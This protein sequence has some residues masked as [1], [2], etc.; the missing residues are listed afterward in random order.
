MRVCIF[1]EGRNAFHCLVLRVHF[2]RGHRRITK[3]VQTPHNGLVPKDAQ[4]VEPRRDGNVRQQRRVLSHETIVK[5]GFVVNGGLHIGLV[6]P[7]PKR[8]AHD[9]GAE[10][11][12]RVAIRVRVVHVSHR[13]QPVA[14]ERVKPVGV[15]RNAPQNGGDRERHGVVRV[16][17]DD[18]P[19]GKAPR[20]PDRTGLCVPRSRGAEGGVWG[21]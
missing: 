11:K 5:D 9:F 12:L 7:R 18:V 14:H 4:A 16:N 8:F 2:G 3:W 17:H 15:A 13:V 10:R 6:L 19:G 20:T 21:T 1:R